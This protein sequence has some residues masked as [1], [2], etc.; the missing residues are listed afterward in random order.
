[1]A[2]TIQIFENSRGL[3][4]VKD[5]KVNLEVHTKMEVT[6]PYCRNYLLQTIV[7]NDTFLEIALNT[8]ECVFFINIGEISD[9][10]CCVIFK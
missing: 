7:K 4:E 5:I 9:R 6:E 3:P 2:Q 1:M 8:I 10:I